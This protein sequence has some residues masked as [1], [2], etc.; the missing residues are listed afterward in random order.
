MGFFDLF[1]KK[2]KP[3]QTQQGQTGVND[4][5]VSITIPE[6]EKKYYQEDEYY[7]RK[8]HEGTVFERTVVTFDERKKISIPSEQGLYVAEILLLDYCSKGTY[9]GPKNGYPGFW[10]FEYGIRDVGAAL[11]SLESRGFIEYSPIK[12]CIRSLTM[13]QL[14]EI[15]AKYDLPTTGKKADLLH[16]VHESVS[17]EDLLDAGVEQK[18]RLTQKGYHELQQNEYIPYMHKCSLKTIE[19]SNF[20]TEYNVWSMNRLLGNVDKS[21]WRTLV[22]DIERSMKVESE[23]NIG[24]L[25]RS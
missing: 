7:T 4:K 15:L 18:Y 16:R 25:W 12:E 6:S 17:E 2:N 1:Y 10:W 20:G 22:E 11:R 19:G 8:T 5:L 23:K 13:P 24:S 14:K 3:K 21:N 9:P